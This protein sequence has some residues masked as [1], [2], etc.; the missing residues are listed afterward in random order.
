VVKVAARWIP[1][2][3]PGAAGPPRAAGAPVPG[4]V[5]NPTVALPRLVRPGETLEVDIPLE[6]PAE[7]GRY[8]VRVALSQRGLGWF[9]IRLQG[10]VDVTAE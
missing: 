10:E 8:E 9:G 5:V 3:E 4:T 1:L 2:D 7:P 6:V